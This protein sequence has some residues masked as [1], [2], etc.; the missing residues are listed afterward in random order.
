MNKLFVIQLAISFI[1]GGCF[2]ALQSFVAERVNKKIAGIII[3]FP[4]TI[5]LGLF[6]MGWATSPESV[7]KIIPSTFIPLGL[8]IL[9]VSIYPYVAEFVAKQVKHKLLQI[10]ISFLVSIGFWFALSVPLVI[11]EVNNFLIGM[12]GYVL[13]VIVAHFILNRKSYSKPVTLKYT[14]LQKITRA[15]FV[16]LII[17]TIVL[18]S[19]ILNPF[20]GGMFSMFPAAFGSVIMIIHWH[21][22]IK[23]LYPIM[24]NAAI[25]SLSLVAYTTV[26]MFAFP[27]YGFV[28]GTIV[29]Y[30]VSLVL[31]LSLI[32][33]QQ[34]IH[35]SK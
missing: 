33:I 30:L 26:V 8:A 9:F 16:G 4:S 20:W 34:K 17:F 35:I 27:A 7:A 1:V 28:M 31:S 10:I 14:N 2:I 24:Q 13:I 32:K 22:G 5:A 15:I 19:K 18:L 25:G 23:S 29:A 3:A 6:F 11:F 12:L 21:Y